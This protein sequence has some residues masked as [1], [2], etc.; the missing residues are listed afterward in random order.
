MDINEK[1][2]SEVI[3]F[4]VRALCAHS[5]CLGLNS[6]NFARITNNEA[7]IFFNQDFQDIL[8]KYKLLD[9]KGRPTF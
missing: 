6:S 5:E 3:E 4:H 1:T 2:F 9:E 8:V 7:P